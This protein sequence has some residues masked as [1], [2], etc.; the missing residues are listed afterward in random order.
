MSQ[1]FGSTQKG[2]LVS[3]LF[4]SAIFRSRS[5][6]FFGTK[7]QDVKTSLFWFWVQLRGS[8]SFRVNAWLESFPFGTFLG[9]LPIKRKG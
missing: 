1:F 9:G 5:L 2:D 7:F 4:F 3:E 6:L 8:I